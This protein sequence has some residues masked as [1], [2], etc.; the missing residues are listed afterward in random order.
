MLLFYRIRI[1]IGENLQIKMSGGLPCGA[2]PDETESLFG[3]CAPC[4][5]LAGQT[6]T[7][8]PTKH[9]LR[10]LMRHTT[11]A[12]HIHAHPIHTTVSFRFLFSHC[13]DG[14]VCIIASFAYQVNRFLLFTQILFAKSPRRIKRRGLFLSTCRSGIHYACTAASRLTAG[15]AMRWSMASR[16][17]AGGTFS[18]RP[19][20]CNK[21]CCACLAAIRSPR[22]M[23]RL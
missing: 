22:P 18:A 21:R 20:S 8:P 2:A 6:R 17:R 19:S 9:P 14:Y 3:I 1:C 4:A 5:P 15:A 11:T 16:T 12:V 13:F 7:Q 10:P 23:R